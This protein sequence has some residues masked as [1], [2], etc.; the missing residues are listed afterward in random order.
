MFD[1]VAFDDECVAEQARG[2]LEDITVQVIK[3]GFVGSLDNLGAIA[4]LAGDYNELPVI[5]Y[6]PDLSWWEPARSSSI[7]RLSR[8]CCCP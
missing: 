4:S 1:H 2:V 6:M 5:A 7:T 3:V 8:N